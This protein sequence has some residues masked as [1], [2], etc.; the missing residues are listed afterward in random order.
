MA[1]TLI[2]APVL[3]FALVA[4][5]SEAPT[6]VSLAADAVQFAQATPERP[7]RA[8]C[9]M[10]IQPPTV[11]SPG[12]IRQVDAGE[13]R[14][15]HLGKATLVSDKVINLTAGT[16]TTQVTFTAANGDVLRANGSGTNVMVAPGIVQ[17]T[18]DMTFVGG[19]GRFANASGHATINGQANIAQA[20]SAMTMEGVLVY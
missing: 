3:T 18:A 4:C 19:T 9:Q 16:Q 1:R 14:A 13:C 5:S 12:V 7:F 8:E 17:F 10:N 11:I 15:L 6:G 2:F 20:R